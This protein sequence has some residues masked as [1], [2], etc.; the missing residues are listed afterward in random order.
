MASAPGSSPGLD[1]CG[2]HGTGI[3]R[4]HHC[5]EAGELEARPWGGT[6]VSWDAGSTLSL[7][8]LVCVVVGGAWG[9][10]IV[11]IQCLPFSYWGH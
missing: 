10:G 7:F 5:P 9:M 8:S 4:P 3:H 6:P 2:P 11:G 1:L